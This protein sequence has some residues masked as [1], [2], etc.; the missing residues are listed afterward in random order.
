GHRQCAQWR[1]PRAQGQDIPKP[2]PIA[3]KGRYQAGENEGRLAAARAADH[4]HEPMLAYLAY[5]LAD[6]ALRFAHAAPAE[7]EGRVFFPECVESSTW[8][9]DLARIPVTRLSTSDG[10]QE[11][12]KLVRRIGHLLNPR[13]I[14][15]G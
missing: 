11:T 14:D 13:E 8:T 9:D 1:A 4:H 10:P 3:P 6:W 7:E 15:P 12:L 2:I 5:K